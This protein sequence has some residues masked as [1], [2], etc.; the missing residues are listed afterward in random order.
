MAD[1]LSE[2]EQIEAIKNWLRTYGPGIAAGIV[3]GLAALAGWQWWQQHQRA[4]EIAASGYYQAML[5]AVNTDDMP[6]ARGQAAVLTDNYGDTT[7][8]V[9][10]ALMLAKFDAEDGNND[11]AI[12]SL[13]WVLDHTKQRD[14]RDIARLRLAR[15]LLA[16]GK[17]EQ[18][19]AQLDQVLSDSFTAEKEEL[20]GDIYAVRHQVKDARMAYEAAMTARG[21]GANNTLL[22]WKLNNLSTSNTQ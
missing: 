6:K 10:A 5:N 13:K 2:Q 4:E 21:P 14:F 17:P 3:I 9:L 7:Y 20:K 18:A 16:Q 11:K 19:R 1:H 22:Q 15:L 8:G 12:A